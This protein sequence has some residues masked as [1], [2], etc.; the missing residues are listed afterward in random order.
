MSLPQLPD[1]DE[2]MS[3]KSLIF[4]GFMVALG[5]AGLASIAEP[6]SAITSLEQGLGAEVETTRL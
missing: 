3:M 6:G 1:D 2:T 5:V 4:W